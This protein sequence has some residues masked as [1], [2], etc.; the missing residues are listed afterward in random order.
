VLLLGL[1]A[2]LKARS[3]SS[4]KRR[5]LPGGTVPTRLVA[6]GRGAEDAQ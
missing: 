3:R 2:W 6:H 4:S 1:L 5:P